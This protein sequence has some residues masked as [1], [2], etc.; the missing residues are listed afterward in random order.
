[1]LVEYSEPRSL[2]IGKLYLIP[3]VNKID[4][5]VW[6]GVATDKKWKRPVEGMIKEGTLKLID[7]RQRVSAELVAKTFD[8]DL[9]EEWLQKAKGPI[10]VKIKKQ[11]KALEIEDAS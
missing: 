5:K 10:K 7:G 2:A 6:E 3:G 4:D 9:L 11:I 8:L 1:M